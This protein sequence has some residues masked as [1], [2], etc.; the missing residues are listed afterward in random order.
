S[1]GEG[2]AK[3]W[4]HGRYSAPYLRDSLLAAGALCETLET[5]TDWSNIGALKAAVT[6]ALTTSLGESGTPALVMCHVSHIYPTGASLYFTVVAGQRGN[7]IEQWWAAKKAACDA[8]MATG[9]TITHHHAVGADHRAWMRDEVGELGVQ[10]LR[11]VK[12]TLDPAGILNPGKL[13][14]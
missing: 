1:L 3:T 6:E 11:A 12:A 2:P 8:I 9:G 5:A 13:I 4:E 7:P 10:L 14:P